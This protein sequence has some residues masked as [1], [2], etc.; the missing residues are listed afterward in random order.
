MFAW[1]VCSPPWIICHQFWSYLPNGHIYLLYIRLFWAV[2]LLIVYR[3]LFSVIFFLFF[4]HLFWIIFLFF[5]I[6]A[7]LHNH[8]RITGLQG[9]GYGIYL[10][11]YYHF[12]PL[13]RRLDIS[14]AITA[15][16]WPL[17]IASTREPLV[18]ERKSLTTKLLVIKLLIF[19]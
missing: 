19:I 6:F 4:F 18:S 11:P 1:W 13:H 9:K 7:F 17:Q 14:W 16:S 10:I 3:K 12:Y 8:S 5:S 15:E 2:F